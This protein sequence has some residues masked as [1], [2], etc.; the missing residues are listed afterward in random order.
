MPVTERVLI[1][2]EALVFFLDAM[3][4]DDAE[5]TPEDHSDHKR[6]ED[7]LYELYQL[8][9]IRESEWMLLPLS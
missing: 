9:G 3:P 4:K 5:W 1:A 2:E 7:N 6:L 8:D